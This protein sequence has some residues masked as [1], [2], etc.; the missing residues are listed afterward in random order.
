MSGPARYRGDKW[1]G[2]ADHELPS[3]KPPET[4]VSK[5][6][7]EQEIDS[8]EKSTDSLIATSLSQCGLYKRHGGGPVKNCASS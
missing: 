7:I 8:F 6:P 2:T 1:M 5:S 3:G 4:V